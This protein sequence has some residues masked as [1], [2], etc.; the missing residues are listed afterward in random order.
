MTE[1][2]AVGAS[3]RGKGLLAFYVAMGAVL[4]LVAVVC[5]AWT[6]LKIRY[7]E[8]QARRAHK[9]V[10]FSQRAFIKGIC[11]ISELAQIGPPAE[12]ALKR[13]LSSRDREL[14][15]NVALELN[16]RGAEWTMPLLV[17]AAQDRDAQVADTALQGVEL[18]LDGSASFS[19]ADELLAWWEREGKAK[20]GGPRR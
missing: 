1:G 3:G 17:F 7:Y 20:Y 14:R 4:A 9:D 18:L 15:H 13:L 8:Q 2:H 12:P 5:F 16:R 19:S 10:P 6:P 11:A